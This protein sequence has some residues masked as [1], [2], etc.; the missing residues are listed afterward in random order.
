MTLQEK[1]QQA[2]KEVTEC[3]Q[4]VQFHNQASQEALQHMVRAD[5]RVK[6]YTELLKEGQYDTQRPVDKP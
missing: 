5:E 2:Q 6:V 3:Q 4:A 1:L